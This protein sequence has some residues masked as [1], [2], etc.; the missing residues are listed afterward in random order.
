MLLAVLP[1]TSWP[2]PPQN[3]P[4]NVDQ[5][6]QEGEE[7]QRALSDE[8]RKI[9][10]IESQYQQLQIQIDAIHGRRQKPRNTAAQPSNPTLSVP[11]QGQPSP[12]AGSASTGGSA[13]NQ[14][15]ASSTSRKAPAT[16]GAVLAAYRAQNALFQPGLTFYPQFSYAYTNS[17][18]LVLNG[19]F[20]FG[21][22]FLGNLNV[23]RSE[24]DVFSWNPEIYYAFNRH[25]ELDVNVP[26]IFARSTFRSVGV[27]FTTSKQSDVTVNKWG[28]GDVSG[29]FYWQVLDQNDSWPSVIWN[30]QASAP[31]GQSP[32]GIKLITDPANSNLKFPSNLPTGKGVWGFSS[33]FTILRQMDPVVLFGSGNYYYELTQHVDDISSLPGTVTPGKAAPGNSLGYS[34][35][36]SWALNEKLNTT[37]QLQ[38]LIVNST[39]VKAD[40]VRGKPTQWQTIPDSSGNAAQFIFGASYAASRNLFPFVQAGIGA[41]QFAPNFQISLWVPYYLD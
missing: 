28:L 38:D 31:T 27:D 32:Y 40:S 1:A 14:V 41:T 35:G 26:Y 39:A 7:L 30:A 22:I 21:S 33:G 36:L 12:V 18:N 15:Q 37:I 20:A 25:F 8:S 34:L 4:A 13:A 5:L 19:F 9:E 24:A 2:Q 3:P 10:F 6:E 17:R 29:G 11:N 23:E 16:S